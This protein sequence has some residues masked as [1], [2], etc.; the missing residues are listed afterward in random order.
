MSETPR[1]S[2]KQL[3]EMGKLQAIASDTP[4]L[5]ETQELRLRRPSRKEM[6]EAERA[7]R[8]QLAVIEAKVR[9]EEQLAQSTGPASL[10][11]DSPAS[12]SGAVL[13]GV[14][15]N[16]KGDPS[17]DAA[18]STP[19]RVSIFD[20]FKSD[21]T[22]DA[23]SQDSSETAVPMV[24]DGADVATPAQAEPETDVVVDEASRAPEVSSDTDEAVANTSETETSSAGEGTLRERLLRRMRANAQN[25]AAAQSV[26]EDEAN[27][28]EA[29]VESAA[30]A[31]EMAEVE[32]QDGDETE[33]TIAAETAGEAEAASE[34][35][36]VVADSEVENVPAAQ[37]DDSLAVPTAPASLAEAQPQTEVSEVEVETEP[38][39][40]S[41]WLFWALIV[42]IGAIV[43]YLIGSWINA[44]F[45]SL[46]DVATTTVAFGLDSVQSWL[47]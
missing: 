30:A 19:A 38:E 1:L 27:E 29:A 46:A 6:R 47:L 11:V 39:S 9:E 40:R 3:R 32:A 45:F 23:D 14:D 4:V 2:R 41:G 7:E 10:S 5:T 24:E 22:S 15:A 21:S 36:A 42:I 25:A 43:G 33:A 35:E 17:P 37:S 44:Q 20:R 28:P 31:G 18:V 13:D 16:A 26:V 34:L 8:E 12:A